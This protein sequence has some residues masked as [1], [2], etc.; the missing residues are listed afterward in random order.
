[1]SIELVATPSERLLAWMSELGAGTW[2]R[3]KDAAAWEFRGLPL[4]EQPKPGLVA[5]HFAERGYL[6]IDW[7]ARRWAVAPT[8]VTTVPG[9]PSAGLVVG[10]RPIRTLRVWSELDDPDVYLEPSNDNSRVDGA[11]QPKDGVRTMYVI[12][13]DVATLERCSA[14]MG[15]SFQWETGPHL[16]ERLAS[17][18]THIL[19]SRRLP[20]PPES[21]VDRYVPRT[22]EWQRVVRPTDVGFYRFRPT[23]LVGPTQFRLITE[24][25]SLRVERQI[26]IYAALAKAGVSVLFYQPADVNGFVYVREDAA[27]PTRHARALFLCSGVTPAIIPVDGVGRCR[28]YVNIPHR[29]AEAIARS[30][31][32]SLRQAIPT[33]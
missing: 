14:R 33:P 29:V 32:Q 27:L 31:G 24:H 8:V 13:D 12:A 10:G 3:F 11:L 5:S 22:G 18:T 26:G 28:R 25:G 30:L 6:E 7:E 19:K 17:M 1:M 21:V 9:L 15:A 23:R 4:D 16:A 20:P 2:Q